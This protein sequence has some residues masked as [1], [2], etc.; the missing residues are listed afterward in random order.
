MKANADE[1]LENAQNAIKTLNIKQENIEKFKLEDIDSGR[2]I[3][4]FSKEKN[5]PKQYPRKA[6][7]PAKQPL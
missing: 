5:T 6:G 7:T 2:T 1:E 3:I 4:V